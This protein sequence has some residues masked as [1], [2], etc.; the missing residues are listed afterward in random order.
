MDLIKGL[1]EDNYYEGRPDQI[2]VKDMPF[3][4]TQGFGAFDEMV[5]DLDE[6]DPDFIKMD[7]KHFRRN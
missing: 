3:I 1:I 4:G 6:I 5:D 7:K 2:A